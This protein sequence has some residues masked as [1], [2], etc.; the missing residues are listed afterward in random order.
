[1]SIKGRI[2][3]LSESIKMMRGEVKMYFIDS[4][5]SLTQSQVDSKTEIYLY[6]EI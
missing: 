1:M 4:I 2:E 3:K 5:N 6:L